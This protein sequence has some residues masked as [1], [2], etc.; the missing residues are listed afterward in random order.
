MW[1]SSW[2]VFGSNHT[3]PYY[4]F[5]C[6]VLYRHQ[7]SVW[8]NIFIPRSW[9]LFGNTCRVREI[10]IVRCTICAVRRVPETK[11]LDLIWN[12]L[13]SLCAWPFW[14]CV[15][16]YSNETA[17]VR[18]FCE[19][20]QCVYARYK[21]KI[22]RNRRL[23]EAKLYIF[24]EYVSTSYISANSKQKS[25][26]ILDVNQGPREFVWHY[27]LR[28]K[29]LMLLSLWRCPGCNMTLLT[30]SKLFMVIDF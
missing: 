29:N 17:T 2:L 19:I 20:Q 21:K 14:Q 23:Q 3:P 11:L 16:K 4:T 25:Q 12:G 15:K 13:H 30:C 7:P 28:P 5:S 10:K 24:A 22:V 26:I 1:I 8:E 9:I 18:H 27:Q 6:S